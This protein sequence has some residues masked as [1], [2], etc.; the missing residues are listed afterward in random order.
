MFINKK[1][2]SIEKSTSIDIDN[3]FVKMCQI[4]MAKRAI[5]SGSDTF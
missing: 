3:I 2:E 4:L 5:H 1:K